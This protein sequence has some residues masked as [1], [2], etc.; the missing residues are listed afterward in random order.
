L[1]VWLADRCFRDVEKKDLLAMKPLE[2]SAR[3]LTEVSRLWLER[4]EASYRI[5]ERLS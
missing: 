1:A 4:R 2:G 3:G 5:L